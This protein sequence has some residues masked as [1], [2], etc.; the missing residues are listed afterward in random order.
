MQDVAQT[1][2]AASD[3]EIARLY[4]QMDSLTEQARDSRWCGSV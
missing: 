4:G 3:D 1:Y 2:R